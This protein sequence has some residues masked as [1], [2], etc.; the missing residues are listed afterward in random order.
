MVGKATLDII[1]RDRSAN[2][3]DNSSLS[4]G[5]L[6]IDSTPPVRSMKNNSDIGAGGDNITNINTPTFYWVA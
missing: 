3:M 4:I 2:A 6:T 1:F 5:W